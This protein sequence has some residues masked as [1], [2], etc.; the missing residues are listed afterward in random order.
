MRVLWTD[1]A[2]DQI[3]AIRIHIKQKGA[4]RAAARVAKSLRELGNSLREHP[5]RGRG[6]GNP[7]APTRE[8]HHPDWPYSVQYLINEPAEQV[9]IVAVWHDAQEEGRT[10]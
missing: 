2:R 5:W 7:Y 10:R 6:L 1:E 4:P 9:I 8:L 3:D